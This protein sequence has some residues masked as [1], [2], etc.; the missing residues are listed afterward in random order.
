[1]PALP[2]LTPA[3]RIR[4]RGL[5]CQA[6]WEESEGHVPPSQHPTALHS[7][8]FSLCQFISCFLS[9][10]S[11]SPL[12]KGARRAPPL[13]PTPPARTRPVCAANV[14]VHHPGRGGAPHNVAPTESASAKQKKQTAFSD[15]CGCPSQ[16]SPHTLS[17]LPSSTPSLSPH[18]HHA[19]AC[20]C[21]S[22]DRWRS[23]WVVRG[24]LWLRAGGRV[25]GEGP[26]LRVS[27]Q[28]WEMRRGD[29]RGAR[30][31]L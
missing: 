30:L 12:L 8:K 24:C 19:C 14:L 6:R 10:F 31:P 22:A 29:T 20:C 9:T 23:A 13:P 18:S 26:P 1:M 2:A 3:S 25:G 5:T 28:E 11:L 7:V 15:R 17:P 4:F 27:R 16:C 21:F